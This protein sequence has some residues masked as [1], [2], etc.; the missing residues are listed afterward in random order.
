MDASLFPIRGSLPAAPEPHPSA[1]VSV[2]AKGVPEN[3][4][5]AAATGGKSLLVHM[6]LPMP[7]TDLVPL[8]CC[9]Y[10]FV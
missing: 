8:T 6:F 7:V 9:S 4:G 5:A 3:N 10:L 2:A 1:L